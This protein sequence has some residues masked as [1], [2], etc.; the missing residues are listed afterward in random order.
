MPAAVART[1]TFALTN[2]TFPYIRKLA[3]KGYV[4]AM[5]EEPALARGLNLW[6]GHVTHPAVARDL[7]LDYFP[8][9]QALAGA[10]A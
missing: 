7:G 2:A 3:D 9:E 8:A 5:R 4:R 10:E 1:S 6:L